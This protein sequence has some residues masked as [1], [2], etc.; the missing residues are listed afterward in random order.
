MSITEKLLK[1]FQDAA[2]TYNDDSHPDTLIYSQDDESLQDGTDLA[3]MEFIE[4]SR[5]SNRYD[6]IYSIP[7][8]GRFVLAT[9]DI[10]KTENQE[11]RILTKAY[12]VKAE[13]ITITKYV[14][15]TA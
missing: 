4:E 6:F 8:E 12:E 7:S 5:W 15:V 1:L 11:H 14:R 2:A 9:V 3:D 13:Q 10:G